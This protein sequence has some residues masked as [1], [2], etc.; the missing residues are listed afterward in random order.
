V[1]ETIFM[2]LLLLFLKTNLFEKGVKELFILAKINEFG[3]M[4]LI[5]V[6]FAII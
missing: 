5:Q 6:S 4:S 2:V 3:L 1:L